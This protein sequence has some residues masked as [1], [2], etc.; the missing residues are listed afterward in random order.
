MVLFGSAAAAE[1]GHCTHESW[2]VEGLPLV[3]T[4]CVPAARTPRVDVGETFTRNG[5]TIARSLSIDVVNG[6]DVTRTIDDVDLTGVGASKQLHLTILYR[7]GTA[8]V[9]H[10]ML[11][12][13]ALVLK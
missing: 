4:L 12:P 6:S 11:L 10:A 13:G 3:A 7:A 1:T 9:E 5:T 2:S 8:T